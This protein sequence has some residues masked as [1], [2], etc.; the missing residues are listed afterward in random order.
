[1]AAAANW[2]NIFQKT[3]TAN[4]KHSLVY[5]YKKCMWSHPAQEQVGMK[6]NENKKKAKYY[7]YT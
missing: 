5:Y 1:M 6:M 7:Y 4:A 2:C 3:S